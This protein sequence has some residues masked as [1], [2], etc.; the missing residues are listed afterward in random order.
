MRSN[1]SPPLTSSSTRK[2]V[3]FVSCVS[4]S[5]SRRSVMLG[6]RPICTMLDISLHTDWR[7]LK[8]RR[9][10]G[11][12]AGMRLS[13]PSSVTTLDPWATRF[14]L[15]TSPSGRC[16]TARGLGPHISRQ[17]GRGSSRSWQ[18]CGSSYAAKGWPLGA[19]SHHTFSRC[20]RAFPWIC[21]PLR[22]CPFTATGHLLICPTMEFL[23]PRGFNIFTATDLSVTGSN[24][25]Y[26]EPD[27]P[28]P[29]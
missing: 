6:C 9:Y 18:R 15:S 16:S 7:L 2:R 23:Y 12:T 5:T 4:S 26:T 22:G 27:A 3:V 14:S 19:R 24:A 29:R 11:E 10:L 13:L 1:S 25:W 20:I 8:K 21:S 28:P 17:R